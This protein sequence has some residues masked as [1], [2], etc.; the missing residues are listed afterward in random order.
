MKLQRSPLKS[1]LASLFCSINAIDSSRGP[2]EQFALFIRGAGRSSQLQRV[3]DRSIAATDAI[4]REVAFEHASRG[5]EHLDASFDIGLPDVCE[6]LGAGR[7]RTLLEAEATAYG[8]QPTEFHDHVGPSRNLGHEGLPSWKRL[9]ASVG[10]D[11]QQ[12]ATVI[13]S[14]GHIG[15][16]IGQAAKLQKL[17]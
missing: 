6:F 17:L 2:A 11:T 15:K 10:P 5:T 9:R 12:A 14:Y 1:P 13:H 16:G 3:P 4:W 7:C 8:G